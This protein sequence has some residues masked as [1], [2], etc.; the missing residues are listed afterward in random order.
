[1]KFYMNRDFSEIAGEDCIEIWDMWRLSYKKGITITFYSRFWCHFVGLQWRWFGA[2]GR[3]FLII[4]IILLA[5]LVHIFEAHCR[6]SI[7]S[8]NR[9]I[10]KQRGISTQLYTP[11]M[12][13]FIWLINV[14]VF[15][16][17]SILKHIQNKVKTLEAQ[18]A[19]KYLAKL[20]A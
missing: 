5:S 20:G 7:K 8:F 3:R 12:H 11:T 13:A 14:Y 10:K 2:F 6:K 18:I 17:V 16:F 15:M 1:M 9:T 19:T 4:I